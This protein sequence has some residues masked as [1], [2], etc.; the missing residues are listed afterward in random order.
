MKRIN[1]D[2]ET[3]ILSKKYSNSYEFFADKSQ[4]LIK[5]YSKNERG[6]VSLHDVAVIFSPKNTKENWLACWWK[7]SIDTN[8]DACWSKSGD[9]CVTSFD[10]LVQFLDQILEPD[11]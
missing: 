8:D 3:D 7:Y 10:Q 2:V 11:I 4:R 6:E 1:F 9:T 5:V